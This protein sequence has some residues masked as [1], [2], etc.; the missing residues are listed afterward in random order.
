MK[1]SREVR[2]RKSRARIWIVVAIIAVP[3]VY[4]AARWVRPV[5]ALQWFGVKTHLQNFADY[6]LSGVVVNED[7]SPFGELTVYVEWG[8]W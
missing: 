6:K 5:V 4:A 3:L 8:R 1:L 2:M 7:G